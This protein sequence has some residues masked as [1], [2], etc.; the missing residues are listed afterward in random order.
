MIAYVS[1]SNFNFPN[2]RK[3]QTNEFRGGLPGSP[4]AGPRAVCREAEGARLNKS[5]G[6]FVFRG[7]KSCLPVCRECVAMLHN[8]AS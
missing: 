1:V 7:P 2:T 5:G 8:G 4:V 6:S 3:T